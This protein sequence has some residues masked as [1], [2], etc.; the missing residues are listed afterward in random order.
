MPVNY[1]E[2]PATVVVEL[3]KRGDVIALIPVGSI[4]QHCSGPLGLDG[5]IAEIIARESCR[6]L[7]ER[8]IGECIILPTLFYGYSP[9]WSSI[10]GT[11]SLDVESYARIIEAIVGNLMDT[12]FKR[13]VVLNGHGGNSSIIE[14]VLRSIAREGYILALVNYWDVAGLRLDHAGRIEEMVVEQL[15]LN[16]KL[17]DCIDRVEYIGK[18]RI[19]A[20]KASK[21]SKLEVGEEQ[22]ASNIIERVAEAL[23]RIIK[24]E[25][26]ERI[27]I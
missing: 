13:I 25:L 10:K 7:E 18:P 1:A 17:G 24:L 15:G 8:R 26:G 16:Y 6:L 2:I 4:E 12:G 3:A 27:L 5:F 21:P 22:L 23:E 19:I 9:E 14:A 20:G 11:I